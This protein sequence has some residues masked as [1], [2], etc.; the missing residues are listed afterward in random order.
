MCIGDFLRCCVYTT[1]TEWEFNRDHEKSNP[2]W[3]FDFEFSI[4]KAT[5]SGPNSQFLNMFVVSL[6]R[7]ENPK[8]SPNIS[9]MIQSF[10][11]KGL[12]RP[13]V[14]GQGRGVR[15]DLIEKLENILAV[16]S[17]ARAPSD[18]NLPGFRLHPAKGQLKGF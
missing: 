12:Q 16:L 7:I 3:I 10:R 13:F 9:K 8:S 4:I 18:M 5:E 6:S 15:T 2:I 14:D 1:S 17:R 11:H